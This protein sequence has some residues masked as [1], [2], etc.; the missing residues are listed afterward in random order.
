MTFEQLSSD[1]YGFENAL[2]AQEKDKIMQ[3]RA[4]LDAGKNPS[5]IAPKR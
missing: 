2:T 3:L 5:L 4:F 1:F